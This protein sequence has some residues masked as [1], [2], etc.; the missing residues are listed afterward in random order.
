MSAAQ[1]GVFLY[2]LL[3]SR[4]EGLADGIGRLGHGLGKHMGV[5]VLRSPGI[6][7]AQMLRNDLDRDPHVYQQRGVGVAEVVDIVRLGCEFTADLKFDIEDYLTTVF[8]RKFAKAED[9]A[10]IN[11]DGIDKPVGILHTEGGAEIGV[12]SASTDSI[13]FDE[14]AR[15]YFSVKP[16]YR[17]SAVWLMNDETALTLRS[18]KDDAGNYLWRGSAESLMGK[19]VVISN[20]MPSIA[21]GKK[22]VAFGDFSYYWIVV[23]FPLTARALNELFAVYDQR[24][25]LGYEFLDGKFIRREAVKALQ[26][27]G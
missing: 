19:P 2:S 20:A 7:V 6:A 3:R 26:M 16:D 11:G 8:A 13:S 18:L 23:R 21:P 9:A 25:Y 12:T 1:S 10:F 15:L 17:S 27:A 14:L 24:G 5:Y 4:G 22:P